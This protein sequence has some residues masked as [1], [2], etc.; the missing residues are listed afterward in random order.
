MTLIPFLR[1]HPAPTETEIR[2][3]LSGHLCRCTGYANIVAAVQRVVKY[4]GAR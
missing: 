2:E 3:A 4:E 1:D